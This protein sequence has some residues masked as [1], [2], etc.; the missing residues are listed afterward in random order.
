MRDSLS[1]GSR[2][3]PGF[4]DGKSQTPSWESESS[5]RQRLRRFERSCWIL[6]KRNQRACSEHLT[7]LAGPNETKVHACALRAEVL[8]RKGDRIVVIAGPYRGRVGIVRRRARAGGFIVNI[9]GGDTHIPMSP[10]LKA[11][12]IRRVQATQ[13]ATG[14]A[15]T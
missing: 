9:D 1:T 14:S 10:R 3:K 12:E 2:G 5:C 7:V 6:L 8:M 11:G 4:P 13:T 15:R